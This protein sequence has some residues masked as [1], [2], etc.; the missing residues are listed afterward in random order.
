ATAP[1]ATSSSCAP[2]SPDCGRGSER[3]RPDPLDAGSLMCR[4]TS[5]PAEWLGRGELRCRDLA[6]EHAADQRLP[7]HRA[8][9]PV[10]GH[11]RYILG[12]GV[13]EPAYRGVGLGAEDTVDLQALA[14]VAGQ[15]TE[16]E[17]LLD[18]TDGVS[19]ATLA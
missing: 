6:G 10:D 9:D 15:V 8:D 19:L 4:L 2:A 11:G 16:L 12:D 13:L 17:L 5:A 3:R 1:T 14:R 7:G 18:A